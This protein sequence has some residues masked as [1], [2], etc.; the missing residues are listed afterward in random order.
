MKRNLGKLVAVL[1]LFFVNATASTYEWSVAQEKIE[2]YQNEAIYLNYKCSFSDTAELYVVEFHPSVDN[3]EYKLEVL[4]EEAR[5][6]DGK[7]I[8]E[9][10]FIL[11]VKKAGEFKLELDAMMKKT[12]KDSIE[13]SVL[14]RDNANYE[15]FSLS[16]IK[17]KTLHMTI[18]ETPTPIVGEF[19]LKVKKSKPSVEAYEPYHLTLEIEG[20]GN[21]D[22]FKEI[23]YTI[24]GVKIFSEP[25]RED[26]T[27]TKNGKSGT[28]TK[29]FAFVSEKSFTIKPFKL[30]YFKLESKKRELLQESAIDVSVNEPTFK[31]EELLDE[32]QEEFELSYEYLYYLLTFLA[33]YLLA[34]IE[35]KKAPKID[36]KEKNFCLKVKE[37]KTLEELSVLLVLVNAKKYEE[38]I[39][40]IEKKELTSLS[41]VKKLICY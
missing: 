13:N 28:W 10:E 25:A 30:E 9:Y 32:K 5:I 3:E 26:L 20:N 14:G 40:Q 15:E 17:Q 7:K 19:S 4:R 12:N 11:V 22:R 8:N 38:I 33:G 31:K 41:K 35:F 24:D 18:L 1:L 37:S 39:L 23:E 6:V 21:F 34:K 16:P 29:K 2:A 27:L 36:D